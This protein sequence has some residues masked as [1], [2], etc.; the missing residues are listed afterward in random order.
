MSA[1]SDD[2]DYGHVLMNRRVCRERRLSQAVR[3]KHAR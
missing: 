1:N 3:V 2:D